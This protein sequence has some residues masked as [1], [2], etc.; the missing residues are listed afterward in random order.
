[1][2][3]PFHIP[4]KGE[5]QYQY[6]VMP[7]GFT[8]DK[9]IQAVEA[10]PSNREVVHH[11]V[12]F[13]RDP[14]IQM[15]ARQRSRAFPIRPPGG[16]KDFNNTSGGGSDILMIYTPGMVPEIWRPGFGKMI[17]A[18]SDLV[19]Q[20]HY[21]PSGKPQPITARSDWSSLKKSPPTVRLRS[22]HPI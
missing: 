3:E 13:I 17:K 2:K 19:F 11:I 9:W 14:K 16:G 10:R 1:M 18:G 8:E 22:L 15:A 5:V 4:A 7:T 20:V 21:R 6:I 12:V